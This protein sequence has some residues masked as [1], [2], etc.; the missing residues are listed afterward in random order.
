MITRINTASE[1]NK[2]TKKEPK[3]HK[4]NEQTEY[5][6]SFGNLAEPERNKI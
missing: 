4:K 3:V 2:K 5:L 1:K 6:S